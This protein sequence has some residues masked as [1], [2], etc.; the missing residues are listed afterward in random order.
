MTDDTYLIVD[1]GVEEPRD[2]VLRND[3]GDAIQVSL[4]VIDEFNTRD[5]AEEAKD[6]GQAIVLA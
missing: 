3:H 2:D 4:P 6:S 1:L 5:A